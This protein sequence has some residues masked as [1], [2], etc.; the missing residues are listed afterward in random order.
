MGELHLQ[1]GQV[2]AAAATIK[3]IIALG[4]DNIDAYRDLLEQIA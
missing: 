1:N 3:A 4:P 2:R